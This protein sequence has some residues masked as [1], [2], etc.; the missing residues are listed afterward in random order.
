ME[1]VYNKNLKKD[2]FEKSRAQQFRD[3][4]WIKEQIG[5][6]AG[7]LGLKAV[8][9]ELVG[10]NDENQSQCEIIVTNTR[11]SPKQQNSKK[12]FHQKLKILMAKDLGFLSDKSYHVFKNLSQ[13]NDIL[14]SLSAL[15]DIRK[16]INALLQINRNSLGWFIFI[17]FL[18]L[19]LSILNY[20]LIYR[21]GF[22]V[23]VRE[24]IIMATKRFLDDRNTI[25]NDTLIVKYGGDSTNITGSRKKILN[26]TFTL[27]NDEKNA[28]SVAGNFII[29]N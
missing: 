24:K 13:L 2:Y 19:F 12:D 8:R 15:K 28:K 16:R 17:Y 3:K 27:I 23:S 25:E 9:L 21:K 22:Y 20:F 6:L 7:Q 29:G 18:L 26:F 14:P 5:L 4:R 11:N 10:E 1:V